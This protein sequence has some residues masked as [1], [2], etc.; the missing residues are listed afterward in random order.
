MT[1]ALRNIL[2]KTVWSFTTGCNGKI[3]SLPLS[4]VCS[5]CVLSRSIW[6]LFGRL[7]KIISDGQSY[8][9]AL[10]YYKSSSFVQEGEHSSVHVSTCSIQTEGSRDG[11]SFGFGISI[12]RVVLTVVIHLHRAATVVLSCFQHWC[13]HGH[14]ATAHLFESL[15]DGAEYGKVSVAKS[16]DLGGLISVRFI[17]INLTQLPKVTNL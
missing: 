9:L 17:P 16:E 7:G 10:D 3:L 15:W 13:P 11:T 8:W 14:V 1:S 6:N 5:L 4:I 12:M 2:G